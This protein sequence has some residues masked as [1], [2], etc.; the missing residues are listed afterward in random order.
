MEGQRERTEHHA[1]NALHEKQG[2]RPG[3]A[4]CEPAQRG[5][6]QSAQ[7]GKG[8]EDEKSEFGLSGRR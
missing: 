7:H 2:A 8:A 6:E 4:Q 1:D 5:D 3:V